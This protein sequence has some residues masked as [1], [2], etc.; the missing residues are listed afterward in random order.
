MLRFKICKGGQRVKERGGKKQREKGK[1]KKDGS[2]RLSVVRKEHRHWNIKKASGTSQLVVS[3][4]RPNLQVD[5]RGPYERALCHNNHVKNRAG[6]KRAGTVC[7]DSVPPAC[8]W[9]YQP[10]PPASFLSFFFL[11][12]LLSLS[13]FPLLSLPVGSTPWEPPH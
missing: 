10:P 1:A 5:H 8:I 7:T 6:F 2:C 12:S 11:S 13:L 4:A 9:I 3:L